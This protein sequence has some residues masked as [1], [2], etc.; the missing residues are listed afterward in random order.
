MQFD[1]VIPTRG[2]LKT[3]T[4]LFHSINKQTVLPQRIFLVFNQ[5]M[6]DAEWEE[7]GKK[8]CGIADEHIA[9]I[10]Q[11]ISCSTAEY[12]YTGAAHARNF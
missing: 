10:L 1:L 11:P 6:N 8:A 5:Y 2:D 9:N 7:F 12:T 3:L 4:P